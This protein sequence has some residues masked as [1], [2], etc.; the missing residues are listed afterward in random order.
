MTQNCIPPSDFII[1]NRECV[2]RLGI[3]E[4][5]NVIFKQVSHRLVSRLLHFCIWSVVLWT[6]LHCVT[7]CEICIVSRWPSLAS[8]FGFTLPQLAQTDLS[9]VDVPLNTK[10]TNS[11]YDVAVRNQCSAGRGDSV[12]CV[13]SFSCCARCLRF[14]PHRWHCW[15][16]LLWFLLYRL[17][18]EEG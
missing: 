13:L 4:D 8:G 9:S 3:G 11:L 14:D 17:P 6:V 7:Y 2:I 16:S 15:P 5:A 18:C 1:S 10:Q 12:V